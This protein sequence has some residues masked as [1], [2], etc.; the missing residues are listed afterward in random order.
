MRGWI[1]A[2]LGTDEHVIAADVVIAPGAYVVLGRNADRSANGGVTRVRLQWRQPGQHRRRSPAARARTGGSRPRRPGATICRSVRVRRWNGQPGTG[3]RHGRR[4]R[5]PGP[6]RPVTW[7]LA[8][9]GVRSAGDDDPSPV[10]P[11]SPGDAHARQR[12]VDWAGRCR[13]FT[14]SEVLANPG[15]LRSRRRVD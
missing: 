2:D 5:R 1:L 9:C 10:D 11:P 4:R 8:R 7:K 6:A 12:A 3:P 14:S 13:R 15:G